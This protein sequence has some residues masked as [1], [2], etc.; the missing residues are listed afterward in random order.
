[1]VGGAVGYLL[2]DTEEDELIAAI[3]LAAA[4]YGA[5]TPPVS[6][7]LVDDFREAPGEEY[8][9]SVTAREMDV[10]RLV[11][12]GLTNPQISKRLSISVSTVNHHVHN[13]LDKLG[14]KT[15]TEAAAIAVREGLA[16]L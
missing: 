2:K 11:A 1:L 12:G 13:L 8:R 15:R 4:G 3:H 7:S 9:V 16:D 6:Q 5:G 10:L 14:A